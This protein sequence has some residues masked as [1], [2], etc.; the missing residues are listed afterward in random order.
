MVLI[1]VYSNLFGADGDP[2]SSHDELLLIIRVFLPSSPLFAFCL[3]AYKKCAERVNV[4]SL[5]F[6]DTPCIVNLS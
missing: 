1:L 5:V 4:W 6:M 3:S 2:W